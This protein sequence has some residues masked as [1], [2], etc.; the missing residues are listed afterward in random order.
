MGGLIILIVTF[1]LM[2]ALFILPQQRRVRAQ[3]ALVAAIGEGDEIMTTAGMFGRITAI[4]GDEIRL[5]VSPGV[6]LRMMKGAIAAD[7]RGW[8]WIATDASKAIVA[9]RKTIVVS[10][11]AILRYFARGRHFS[12]HFACPLG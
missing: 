3:Q 6:E 4:E 11:G 8:L 7:D 5:E 9:R 2:W 10:P 1:G 12:R